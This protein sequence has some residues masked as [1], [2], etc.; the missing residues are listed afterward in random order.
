MFI[1]FEGGEACGKSTQVR[2]LCDRLEKGG[3]QVVVTHDP[4]F[5][6]IGSAIRHLLLHAREGNKM[7]PETELLLFAASRA[8]LVR[9]II[10]PELE[11]GKIVLSDRFHDST[12]I[13]QGI[14]RGIDLDFIKDLNRFSGD[15]LCPDRTFLL[16][17]DLETARQRKL[18]RVRPVDVSRDRIEE[19]PME[20][21]EKIRDGY[22]RL[23][24]SESK[25]MV[26]IDASHSEEK[27]EQMIWEKL[28]GL[29]C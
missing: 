25:R 23:A 21:F 6:E 24:E 10:K 15:G 5:T 4:G 11:R 29:L 8:Q 3:Y 2:R 14:G 7:F 13:Y 26:I 28:H 1:T 19:M 16:D 20:F 18:R 17:L 22:L 9:E 27:V 12:E